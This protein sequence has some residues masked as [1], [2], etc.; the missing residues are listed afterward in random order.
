MQLEPAHSRKLLGPLLH[1]LVD[2]VLYLSAGLAHSNKPNGQVGYGSTRATDLLSLSYPLSFNQTR[3]MCSFQLFFNI[4]YPGWGMSSFPLQPIGYTAFEGL[5]FIRKASSNRKPQT[6]KRPTGSR[7]GIAG[8]PQ[9]VH[10]LLQLVRGFLDAF[11]FQPPFLFG[12]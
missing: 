9:E 7:L 4:R 12:A 2:D 11:D 10:H 8:A 1:H 5:F 6:A 3:I